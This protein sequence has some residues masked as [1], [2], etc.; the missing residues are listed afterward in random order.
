MATALETAAVQPT[1]TSAHASALSPAFAFAAL[2]MVAAILLGR[3][4]RARTAQMKAGVELV[5]AL[6]GDDHD[7]VAAPYLAL[8]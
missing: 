3:L 6:E 4:R 8:D 5:A 7:E 1:D 2:F